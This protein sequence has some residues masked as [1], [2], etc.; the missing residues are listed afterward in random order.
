MEQFGEAY[1][2]AVAAPIGAR[3]S[4]P[5]PDFDA[6]DYLVIGDDDT[7]PM[8]GIQLKTTSQDCIRNSVLSLEI[9]IRSFEIL[10]NPDR[11]FP[12]LILVVHVPGDVGEWVRHSPEELALRRCGYVK[13]LRN[14]DVG[15]GEKTRTIRI[16]TQNAFTTQLLASML[17]STASPDKLP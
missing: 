4:K 12:A 1:L 7:L 2:R 14:M 6:I 17:A 11:H 16:P 8:L 15:T 9:D 3:L 10:R 5:L 13:S